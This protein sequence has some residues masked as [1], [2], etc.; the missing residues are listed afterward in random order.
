MSRE[1]AGNFSDSTENLL[2]VSE[3]GYEINL[4][5]LE[6][7]NKELIVLKSIAD[8][9]EERGYA[10][11]KDVENYL[12][13]RFDRNWSSGKL[14]PA[15]H[16]L[17]EE[18]FLELKENTDTKD[19]TITEEGFQRL[20]KE[21]KELLQTAYCLGQQYADIGEKPEEIDPVKRLLED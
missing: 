10:S 2:E 17:S 9:Q 19:Y 13:D 7:G 8:I 1:E 6:Y 11:G 3:T 21:I 18:G 15:I 4:D 5:V 14:Y 20:G 12:N 16:N